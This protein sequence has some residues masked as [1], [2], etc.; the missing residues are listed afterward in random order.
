M[1][2]FL[3]YFKTPC[4]LFLVCLCSTSIFAQLPGS[5]NALTFDGNDDRVTNSQ[6]SLAANSFTM[7]LWVNPNSTIPLQT[8]STG[9]TSGV[10]GG[11][12]YAVYPTTSYSNVNAGAGIS[13]GTNGICVMEHGNSYIPS[14]LTWSGTINGW[15]HIAVVYTNKQPK[16]YV[17]GILVATGLTS[18]RSNVYA[19]YQLGGGDHGH[20]PGSLDEFRVWN[21][22]L[23]EAQIRERMCRKIPSSD[24]L[25]NNLV[26]YYNFDESSGNSVSDAS[27][28]A[29]NGTLTNGPIR[30][31]S[32]AA[33]GNESVHDYVNATKTA[34]I[35]HAS[36]ETFTATS[37]AGNPSG[38]HVFSVNETPNTLNGT[39]GASGINKYFGVFQ[40]GGS[41]PSY[42]AVYNY[43]GSPILTPTN[44]AQ[45]RLL[46]RNNNASGNWSSILATPDEPNNIITISSTANAEYL[47]AETG[48]NNECSGAYSLPVSANTTCININSGTT[49]GATQ[50]LP[51]CGS[52]GSADDDVW[53]KFVATSTSH[54]IKITN[55]TYN[56][57]SQ[58]FVGSC[59]NL[60]S[61]ACQ[62]Q[63]N[64]KNIDYRVDNLT[65]G[66][67]VYV[68]VYTDAN[69]VYTDFD[70][71]VSTPPAG[72]PINDECSGA[73]NLVVNPDLN[74]G[75][76]YNG[77]TY[78]A[79]QSLPACY[80]TADD[81]VWFK[82]TATN[83]SHRLNLSNQNRGI[84]FQFYSGDC[85]T[86]NA[87]SCNEGST[88]QYDNFIVGQTYYI[89]LYT[90][91]AN[92]IYTNFTICIGTPPPPPV[93]DECTGAINLLVNSDLNCGNVLNTTTTGGTPSIA[94]CGY[95]N[96][97]DDV[98]FKFVASSAS[99]RVNISNTNNTIG[100]Q[101][102]RGDCNNL[103]SM[104][105]EGLWYVSNTQYQ[106]NNLTIGETYYIRMYSQGYL[107]VLNF[108]I[109]IGDSRVNAGADQTV[110]CTNPTA[111]LTATSA[112]APY[113]WSTGETATSISV[114]PTV[115]TTYSVTAS[116]GT[117]DDVTVFVNRTPPNISAGEM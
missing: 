2:H 17:N 90:V 98:W 62:N 86:L 96:A 115:T 24:P 101:L 56:I 103:T 105:C 93:N 5:G 110:T 85:N 18:I 68:R 111:T 73:I 99:H 14:L 55:A 102:F 78:Y 3:H 10:S 28:T 34:S 77:T 12:R 16:L 32:G 38:I 30:I 29:N 100:F 117:T 106:F 109:C 11:G 6:S 39:N 75:S 87:F 104:F 53:Y 72:S 97:D 82:F 81:D 66:Q 113:I 83:T 43:T 54:T 7:E 48:D 36:G 79:T 27:T 60:S 15:T 94:A 37:T 41:S 8:P 64:S 19:S 114:S 33:I 95:G 116:N 1:K 57:S 45:L 40:V 13:V 108:T 70:I 91:D 46:K 65:I 89:R 76:V 61:I 63:Q 88:F 9:G 25:Y 50:S 23:T 51:A 59:A 31:T 92:F 35:T 84:V 107:D 71:C 20:Y 21:T 49:T 47:L 69:A 80:G 58:A 42:Q 74:C 4:L 112:E 67:T 22:S 52:S 44:E 26:I